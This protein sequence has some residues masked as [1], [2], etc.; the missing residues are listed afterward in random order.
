MFCA[1]ACHGSRVEVDDD[2]LLAEVLV[3]APKIAFVVV[4]GEC[5]DGIAYIEASAG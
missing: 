3:E 5:S 2:V 4:G 1:A